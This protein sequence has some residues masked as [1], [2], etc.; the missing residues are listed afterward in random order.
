MKSVQEADFQ[1]TAY[2]FTEAPA[3]LTFVQLINVVQ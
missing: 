1:F 2:D 3:D